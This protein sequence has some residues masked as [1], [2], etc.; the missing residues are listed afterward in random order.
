M[1]D[2]Y[3]LAREN[4]RVYFLRQDHRKLAFKPGVSMV[5]GELLVPF[6]GEV[7][8]VNLETG[9]V[10]GKTEANFEESLSVYDWLFHEGGAASGEFCPVHA[11]PGV[12]VRGSG[13]QMS[14]GALP[15]LIDQNPR[16]F[17][18]ICENLGGT[19]MP[20][21]DMAY[22]LPVFPGLDMMLKFY[23]AD[24]DFPPQ[25]TCLWDRNVLQFLRYETVYYVAGCLFSKLRR[26]MTEHQAFF[27]N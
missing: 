3:A 1:G 19:P 22:R 11:L 5:H 10:C 25:L 2:N 7:Y 6:L 12:Y 18:E 8:R 13:L 20:L 24:E 14:G 17:S 23:H 27:S 4:A 15:G 9:R 16:K 26:G 21:G